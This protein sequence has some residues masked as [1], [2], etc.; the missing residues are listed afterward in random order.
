MDLFGSE[1]G[2]AEGSCGYGNELPDAVNGEDF[3]E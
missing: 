2:T 1:Y 3:I